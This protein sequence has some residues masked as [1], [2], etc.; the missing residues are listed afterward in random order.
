MKQLKWAAACALLL[1]GTQAMACYTVY[2]VKGRVVYRTMTAPV[3]MSLELHEAMAASK[4]PAGSTLVFDG[5]A[6]CT[7]VA[8]AQVARPDSSDVP[9]NTLR[10]EGSGRQ[11][12]PAAPA[13]PA[14]PATGKAGS[15]S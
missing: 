13:T 3:D 11:I 6:T 2:D 7:A 14:T 10:M 8:V 4:F 9:A 12:S 5:G 1:A 15:A